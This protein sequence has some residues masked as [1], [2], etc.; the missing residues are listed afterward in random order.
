MRL[1]LTSV[2]AANHVRKV[3]E[4]FVAIVALAAAEEHLRVFL[5]GDALLPKNKKR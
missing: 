3:G 1:P 4:S 5:H 2:A